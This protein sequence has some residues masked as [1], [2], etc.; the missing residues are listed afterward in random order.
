MREIFKEQLNGTEPLTEEVLDAFS[1]KTYYNGETKKVGDVVLYAM[2]MGDV[3]ERE[4][5]IPEFPMTLISL[6]ENHFD[7]FEYDE[8]HL[9]AGIPVIKLKENG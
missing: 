3:I 9:G 2:L 5:E 1:N 7:L 4:G 6:N 8:R